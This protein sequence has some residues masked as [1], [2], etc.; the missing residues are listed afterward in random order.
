MAAG[1]P[2]LRNALAVC[3][4]VSAAQAQTGLVPLTELGSGTY[5]GFQGGLYPGGQNQPPPAHATAAQLRAIEIV[6]RDSAGVPDPAGLIAMIAIGMSNTTHEFGAFER[7][8]DANL[9]RNPRVVIVDTGFG[10]QTATIVANPSAAYWTTLE[11]R[12]TVLGLTPAQVQVAWLKEAE[13]NPPNDFPAHAQTLRANLELIANNLHDKFPNLKLCHVSSRIYG[14]YATGSLNPEPQAYESGF[15][16]RWLIEDQINGDPGLNYGQLPGPVRAPL[17]LWG[18][19]LWAD[20]LDARADGLTWLPADLEGDG[21][22]PSP[23][24]EQKVARLLSEFLEAEP[25]AAPWWPWQGDAVLVAVD[26]GKD[27]HVSAASPGTNFGSTTQLLVQGGAQPINAYVGFQLG[28]APLPAKLVKLSL[29]VVQ[30]GGGRVWNVDDTGWGEG[31]ITWNNAPP[32]GPLTVELPQSSRDG[33]IG[34]DVTTSV[35]NDPDGVLSFALTL[36]PVGPASYRSREG[37][38]PPRLVLV[39]GCTGPDGDGDGRQDSCDCAPAD[40]T[41][42]ARPREI[43]NLRWQA[44]TQLAWDSDAAYSGSGTRYDVLRGELAQVALLAGASGD[45]CMADDHPDTGIGALPVPSPGAGFFY[46]VRGDNACGQGRYETA[47]DGRDRLSP[48]CD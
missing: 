18:P 13:A 36:Q 14:G 4:A 6:P 25:T 38:E 9:D 30:S 19:Y 12:L 46:L 34:A 22:H 29:R 23:S 26:A 28:S 3:F 40:G 7:R 35:N 5:Q 41:A 42:F 45:F 11:S 43:D 10:G 27:A 16:V 20:G 47:S 39:V 37:A 48:A 44:A 15:S 8:E 33:T 17:L 31:S 32:M 2:Y 1:L 21:V 24:G